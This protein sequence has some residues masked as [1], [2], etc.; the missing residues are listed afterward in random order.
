MPCV[1]GFAQRGTQQTCSPRL[2]RLPTGTPG[3]GHP[4]AILNPKQMGSPSAV[5]E[6]IPRSSCGIGVTFLDLPPPFPADSLRAPPPGAGG[7]TGAAR[8]S[9]LPAGRCP[10]TRRFLFLA[11]PRDCAG[12]SLFLF[13]PGMPG[14][15]PPPPAAAL[16]RHPRIWATDAALRAV[17]MSASS[18]N[19]G[20]PRN[21]RTPSRESLATNLKTS[22]SAALTWSRE[23]FW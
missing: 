14:E 10:A 8:R 15:P 23:T 19:N 22:R 3:C 9:L 6:F 1:V 16:G 5:C 17:G 20:L 12:A 2:H 21:A 7:C 11:C 4:P 13:P 18:G